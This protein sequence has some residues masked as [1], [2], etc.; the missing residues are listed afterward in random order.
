MVAIDPQ[1]T[2]RATPGGGYVARVGA[3]YLHQIRHPRDPKVIQEFLVRR[4]IGR[5]SMNFQLGRIEVVR[6]DGNN[7]TKA[8]VPGHL[9]QHDCGFSLETSDFND[10]PPARGAGRDHSQKAGFLFNQ[11]SGDFSSCFPRDVE[12]RIQIARHFYLRQ[13]PSPYYTS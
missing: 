11:K 2:D 9:G 1:K 13:W 5:R 4:G 12:D 3:V 7:R 6:V 10:A 8:I